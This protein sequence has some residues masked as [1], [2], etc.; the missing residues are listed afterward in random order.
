MWK[1]ELVRD[2]FDNLAKG[3]PDRILKRLPDCCLN[4]RMNFYFLIIWRIFRGLIKVFPVSSRA[5][6]Y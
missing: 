4:E 5:R 6:K 3:T 1:A 2:V